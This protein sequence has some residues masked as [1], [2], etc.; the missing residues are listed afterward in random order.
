MIDADNELDILFTYDI[1]ILNRKYEQSNSSDTGE[2]EKF[3]SIRIL[4]LG[5]LDINYLILSKISNKGYLDIVL[6]ILTIGPASLDT[7]SFI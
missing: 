6:S 1:V 3:A 4:V 7:R 5:L 2:L